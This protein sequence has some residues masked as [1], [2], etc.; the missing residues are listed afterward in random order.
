MVPTAG[1]VSSAA[2]S[3]CLLLVNAL[4]DQSAAVYLDDSTKDGVQAAR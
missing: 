4:G 3:A 1:R 2:L